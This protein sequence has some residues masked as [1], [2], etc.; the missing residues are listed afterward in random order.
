MP[1]LAIDSEA[2]LLLRCPEDWCTMA[3]CIER[4]YYDFDGFVVGRPVLRSTTCRTAQQWS[5][6]FHWPD[7]TQ[8]FTWY[9]ISDCK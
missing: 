6:A 3:S 2:A 5:M 4:H 8:G 1:Q 9:G 7:Q